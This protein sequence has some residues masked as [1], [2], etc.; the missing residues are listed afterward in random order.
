MHTLFSDGKAEP[1][2]YISAARGAGLN[3]IGFS[4][5]L[6][7]FSENQEWC[8]DPSRTPEYI[9]RIKS[10]GKG[11]KDI[12]IRIGLEVDYFPDGESRIRNFLS[13]VDLDYVIGSVHYFGDTTVDSSD[14]FY[15]GKDIDNLYR[16]Y[17]ELLYEAAGS[18]L[19]DILG[20][21]DLL[22][23]YN[24]KP[25]FDPE[26]LYRE[27][28]KRLSRHDLAFEINTNGRNRVLADF[29]PDRRYIHLFRKENVPV[30]VNSDAH[31]PHRIGQYF[32][33]A[34]DLLKKAGYTE[35]CAFK[36]RERFMIPACF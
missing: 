13:S 33:E 25:T 35:M 14:D 4:E 34:Y 32:D 30:C 6:N 2:E 27:L 28:A 10:I 18:G 9:R 8:M 11:E 15:K 19:F 3:E 12:A 1:E 23:I 21:A 20:H 22:R 26:Y 36:N 5:H 29:Y 7:L 17:F 31:F 16:S 24:Y